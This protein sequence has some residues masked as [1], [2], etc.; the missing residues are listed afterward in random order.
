LTNGIN[1]TVLVL[2][3]FELRKVFNGDGCDFKERC[4]RFQAGTFLLAFSGTLQCGSGSKFSAIA[5]DC[6]KRSTSVVPGGYNL[7]SAQ[8]SGCASVVPGGCNLNSAKR[9]GAHQWYPEGAT[10]IVRSAADVHQWYPEGAT[11]IVRS[12]A[13][14]HQWYPEGATSIVRSAADVH[15]WYPEGATSIARSAAEHISGTR[16]VQPQ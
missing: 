9:S 16:R 11:S 5:L 8:R 3:Q 12:A 6:I 14:V 15:Q 7:N 4:S 10:S 2:Y 13:D 1:R